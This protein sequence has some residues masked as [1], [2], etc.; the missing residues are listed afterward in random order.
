MKDP[1]LEAAKML[2]STLKADPA[3][4]EEV[5][6]DAIAAR[7]DA[8]LL[9]PVER[10]QVAPGLTLAPAGRIEELEGMLQA[11][12]DESP[13]EPIPEPLRDKA[14][15]LLETTVLEDEGPALPGVPEEPDPEPEPETDPSEGAEDTPDEA[16]PEAE[17]EEANPAI[18][19]ARRRLPTEPG[20]CRDC[21]TDLDL[22]QTKVSSIRFPKEGPLCKP[23]M[24]SH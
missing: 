24:A 18:A 19:P 21:G 16:Q 23:C 15:A 14:L 5:S 17:A 4:V 10:L 13:E 2:I 8:G 22:E 20:Q 9:I 1:V 12:L 6:R 7:I 3:F 11:F